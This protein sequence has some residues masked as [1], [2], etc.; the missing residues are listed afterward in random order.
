MYSRVFPPAVGGMERFAADVAG[1]LA[2]AG[3]RVVVV[4]QTKGEGPGEEDAYRVLRQ[5][6]MATA[7][8]AVRSADVVH[9]NGLSLRGIA[10][11]RAAGT[12][13]VVTHAGH[14]AVCP[15]GLAWVAGRP[16]TAGPRLGP[17]ATCPARGITGWGKVRSHR[18][19]AVI[20]DRNV[21]VSRY[22]R[23][24][25][26]IRDAD[27]IYN[28]VSERAFA[29][30]ATGPGGEALV[31]F[32]GRLVAEKGV[33]L[34]LRAI[35][36]VP[37][38]RLAVAGDGPVRAELERLALDLGLARRVRFLGSVAFPAVAELYARAAAVCV[39]STWNEPFGYSAAEAMAIGRAVVATPRGALTE[40][41]EDGR[42]FL[43]DGAST[44]DL[45]QAVRDALEDESVRVEAGCRARAFARDH[46]HVDATACRYQDIYRQVAV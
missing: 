39:P 29:Q 11:A 12:P 32:A 9:V 36:Q 1:W 35:E 26:G 31:A 15:T 13:T 44:K 27:V 46:L 10:L 5:P 14:Q 4:T 38:V 20:A 18:S 7:L 42:G 28:P 45:A 6:T 40:L 22:L 24:R 3:H 33:G 34:L 23:R 30:T 41:L 21:A 8:R 43:A 17:C 16:C 19:G 37:G 2:A 25:V